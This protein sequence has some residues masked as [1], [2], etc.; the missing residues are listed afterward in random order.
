[1]R[2]ADGG[3]YI[4]RMTQNLFGA[5]LKHWRRRRGWSQLDLAL[6]ADVSA[7]HV[8][9]LESGRA[10]PSEEMVL[11][12]LSALEV[13]LRDQNGILLAASFPARFAEPGLDA[14]HPSIDL[15]IARILRQQE[16][17]PLTVMTAATT[18]SAPT[19]PPR[20]FFPGSR[21]SRIV[22]TG[23]Q[24]CLTRCLIRGG[25]ARSSGTG[26]NWAAI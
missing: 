26:R 5:L 11:R 7:R 20:R 13:P 2:R 6:G 23:R 15:A 9:F 19:R 21:R 22:C 1:L 24:I 17:F 4:W 10:R 3:R 16:P 25:R 14:I 8:S 18:S 12:L